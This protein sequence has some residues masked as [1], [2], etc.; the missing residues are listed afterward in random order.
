V[1]PLLNVMND[2][3]QRQ[4]TFEVRLCFCKG[5]P[6]YCSLTGLVPPADTA[7]CVTARLG[8]LGEDFGMGCAAGLQN[9]QQSHMK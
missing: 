6:T 1:Y 2:R 3:Q 8:M 7:F 4:R 5:R 9:T